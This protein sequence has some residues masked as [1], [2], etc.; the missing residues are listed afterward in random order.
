MVGVRRAG[1]SSAPGGWGGRAP[2][3]PPVQRCSAAQPDPGQPSVEAG[4]DRGPAD[5]SR[6]AAAA[7]PPAPP[8]PPPH[9]PLLRPRLQQH[10]VLPPGKNFSRYKVIRVVLKE[11]NYWTKI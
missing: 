11:W 2:L 8:P 4:L 3:V 6:G 10:Q 9:P 7:A 5:G 1:G